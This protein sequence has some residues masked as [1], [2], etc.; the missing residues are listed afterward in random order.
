MNKIICIVGPTAVG[1]TDTSIALAKK[2]QTEIVSAD[3][4]Q[5]Y[6]SLDI[7]S[8]K[9]TLLERDGVVHHML[10]CVSPYDRFSV[11]E[12]VACAKK[13]IKDLHDQGKTPLVVGG[14]GLYINGLMY[15][16]HFG[17]QAA[18]DEYRQGLEQIAEKEGAEFLHRRLLAIDPKAA[19]KIHPNNIR[20]V[21]R[22]LEINRSTG[23]PLSDFSTEPMLTQDYEVVLIGLMRDRESLYERINRRVELMFQMGLLEEVKKLKKI[24]LNDRNQSMQGIGYKEVLA[25]LEG[26]FS[27]EEMKASIAQNSRHYAKRQMTWFRRYPTMRW[28]DITQKTTE[29]IIGEILSIS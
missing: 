28:I 27:Y 16:M 13:H 20:R 17:E 21:I 5:I 29:E 4:V 9:P 25:Y 11:S 7:G 14:T 12:Y 18:D 6:Q 10:D 2:L 22:A 3:S 1:K 24:G 8:A 23:K 19:L 26:T 15:D